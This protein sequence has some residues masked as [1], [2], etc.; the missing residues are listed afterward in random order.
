MGAVALFRPL[1]IRHIGEEKTQKREARAHAH[2][3]GHT[4]AHAHNTHARTRTTT[5]TNEHTR[6][7]TRMLTQT[8]TH[9]HRNTH[10]TVKKKYP[11]LQIERCWCVLRLNS[12]CKYYCSRLFYYS[13]SRPNYCTSLLFK[14]K[15]WYSGLQLGW[16]GTECPY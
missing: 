15:I 8:R 13:L 4:E 6:T 9:A 14:N 12:S 2:I 5:H 1:G 7:N 3:H 10:D 16:E 11:C